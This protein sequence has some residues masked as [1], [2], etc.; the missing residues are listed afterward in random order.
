MIFK[1]PKSRHIIASFYCC[2]SQREI[3]TSSKKQANASEYQ[4]RGYEQ[5]KLLKTT[6]GNLSLVDTMHMS[7]L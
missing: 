1:N 6:L 2:A 3:M 4:E 7:C 5:C